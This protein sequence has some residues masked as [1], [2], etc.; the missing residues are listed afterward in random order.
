MV[1]AT[2]EA[3]VEKEDPGCLKKA[4]PQ[5][6]ALLRSGRFASQKI[7]GIGFSLRWEVVR[8]RPFLLTVAFIITAN[9]VYMGIEVDANA[10]VDGN[11]AADQSAWAAVEILFTVIFLV[12]LSVRFIATI[13]VKRF[14]KSAWNLF[15]LLIVAVSIVDNILVIL[16]RN[17]TELGSFSVLRSLRLIRLPSG[18]RVASQYT[19]D[20]T[21]TV[22]VWI[23]AGS[24][25][26]TKDDIVEPLWLGYTILGPVENIQQASQQ[27]ALPTP[28]IPCIH[29]VA[30]TSVQVVAA[31]GPVDHG[32]LVRNSEELF[33]HFRSGDGKRKEEGSS[34]DFF[35]AST[36]TVYFQGLGWCLVDEALDTLLREA[37]E[38]G[39]GRPETAVKVLPEL[40]NAADLGQDLCGPHP[41]A[42]ASSVAALSWLVRLAVQ[43]L[44]SAFRALGASTNCSKDCPIETN[45]HEGGLTEADIDDL[46]SHE[47]EVLQGER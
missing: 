39:T 28:E 20:E 35:A 40:I 30:L 27:T 42:A 14:F 22:G 4:S 33:S 25:F 3:E 15:D 21:V 7:W 24:R 37:D 44:Q 18:M 12:E 17:T 9:A 1:K 5:G 26:E 2:E 29:F 34:C 46:F 38:A 10:D 11:Q 19:P 43:A 23:D 6:S 41:E 13:P 47:A 36:S 16:L 8:T 45:G 32:E 31:A